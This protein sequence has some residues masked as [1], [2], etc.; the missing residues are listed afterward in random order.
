METIWSVLYGD[1]LTNEVSLRRIHSSS[2]K[3]WTEALEEGAIHL[4]MNMSGTSLVF[5]STTRMPMVTN[6]LGIAHIGSLK[7]IIASFP[8][9]DEPNELIV[10]CV[11]P[12]WV[13]KN[14]GSKK[15]SLHE[16]LVSLLDKKT[17]HSVLLNKVRSMSYLEHELC[18]ALLNP[19]VHSDAA[20]FWYLAKIIELLSLHLFKPPSLG[21]SE[22]FCSNQKRLAKERVDKV[23]IWLEKNLDQSLDLKAL[24]ASIHCSSSYLSRVFSE[25]TGTTI[26]KKLRMLR[27]EKAA[28]LLKDGDFNVTE[29]A[30]EVGYNSVSHFTKAFQEA[31]GIKPSEFILQF[32]PPN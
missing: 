5:G 9:S 6:T 12:N 25:H 4:F 16:N 24:A 22:T 15:Q 8:E 13:N 17:Q 28:N 1:F 10:L 19:P 18:T 26:T 29:A 20:S 11:T 7:N 23:L 21:A 32:Q 31:K 30:M 3:T 14:F 27:I 2:T